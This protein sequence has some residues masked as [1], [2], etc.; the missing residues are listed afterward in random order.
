M[1]EDTTMQVA[2]SR[3]SSCTYFAVF[4]TRRRSTWTQLSDTTTKRRR[5]GSWFRTQGSNLWVARG[6]EWPRWIMTKSS[7]SEASAAGS[8]RMRLCFNQ[9]RR[10]WRKLLCLSRKYSRSK[11]L[12]CMR[13]RLELCTQLTGRN[14]KYSRS[15]QILG[16]LY[17]NWKSEHNNS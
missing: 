1:R 4:L 10:K 13:R 14:L 12:R 6:S 7:C 11:C 3:R 8:W 17:Q 5:T 15:R 2:V 16:A 9:L